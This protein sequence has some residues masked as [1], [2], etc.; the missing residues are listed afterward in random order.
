MP[1]RSGTPVPSDVEELVAHAVRAH[2]DA[3]MRFALSQLRCRADAEDATQETFTRLVARPQRF[4]NDDHLRAW[5]L[6]VACNVC[7]DLLR[8]RRRRPTS[9]IDDLPVEPSVLDRTDARAEM[10]ALWEALERLSPDAR[11]V[12][13]LVCYEELSYRD[14]AAALGTTEDAVRARLKRARAKLRDLCGHDANARATAA[15]D[16]APE[17]TACEPES[18]ARR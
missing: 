11:A 1:D 15:S 12:V 4:E 5:L 13:H 6:H 3:V 16:D 17:E 8:R 10:E 7:R 18:E 9:P 2:A 14:A